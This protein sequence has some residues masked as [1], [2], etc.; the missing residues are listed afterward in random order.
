MEKLYLCILMRYCSI[1]LL[2]LLALFLSCTDGNRMRVALADLQEKNQAD[3]LLTNDSLALALTNYFDHH[4]TANEK[5][6]AH[7]LL[8]RTYT[9]MGEA[10]MALDEFHTAAEC[11]DTTAKDCDYFILCRVY[12][13]MTSIFYQQNLMDNYLRYLDKSI[14][15][16]EKAGDMMTAVNEQAYKMLAYSRLEKHDSVLRVY[17]LTDR[18]CHALGL[19][20]LSARYA[21]MAIPSCLKMKLYKQARQYMDIFEKQSGLFDSCSNI[22][23]GHEIYYYSKGRYYLDL[24]QNDSA[25]YFF[26]K[27]LREGKDFNNQNAASH[28]LALLFTQ[29]G[30]SDSAAKYALYSY[31]MNDSC[32]A[33]MTT[34]DVE[35]IQSL[36]SYNR[37]KRIAEQ[38]KE[39][40]NYE[41]GRFKV[42]LSIVILIGAA[43][44]Y[45]S[46]K[47][48]K[49]RKAE[50]KL[51]YEQLDRLER[52][53]TE[54]L[55]LRSHEDELNT[56]IE[57]KENEVNR[58][59]LSMKQF[60]HN[61]NQSAEQVEQRLQNSDIYKSLCRKA[62]IG[63]PFSEAEWH[64]LNRLVMEVIPEF[65]QFISN[66]RYALNVN[67]FRTCILFRIHI[68]AGGISNVL[69]VTPSYVTKMSKQL[70]VKLFESDGTSKDL[71]EKLLAIC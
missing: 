50:Q 52:T 39:K 48:H 16:A 43:I 67:E 13:Q 4:G 20:Q 46:S 11:A 41:R 29:I 51:Y 12:A 2:M 10:P 56:L 8:A 40:A 24:Q 28:G 26:R 9:D 14:A 19:G 61:K 37:Y 3:S 53:Q 25:E 15:S 5:M 57:E 22:K 45:I 55:R 47:W 32:F 58:L 44:I 62:D 59:H 34:E 42:F 68:K 6:L 23:T 1:F 7:Y 60:V 64:E 71:I 18:R 27:E 38:E 54:L 33:Q 69:D 65:Y 35:K 36:Y 70:L 31:D 21:G 49:K 17:E 66:K 30:M 63:K